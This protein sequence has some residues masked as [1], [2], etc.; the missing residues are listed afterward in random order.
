MSESQKPLARQVALVTGGGRGLGRA[1]A[2]A[3]AEA[4]ASVTITARSKEQLEQTAVLLRDAGHAFLAL[5]GDVTNQHSVE[6]IVQRTE[7]EWG[8]SIS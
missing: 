8:V 5:E 1:M 6:E 2:L 4:G 7:Q 3:L